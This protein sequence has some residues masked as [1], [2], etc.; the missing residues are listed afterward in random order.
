MSAPDLEVCAPWATRDLM[1]CDDAEF[2]EELIDDALDAASSILYVLSGRQFPGVCEETIRPCALRTDAPRHRRFGWGVWEWQPLWW[3][4]GCRSNDRCACGSLSQI[5]LRTPVASVD[6]VLVDG[7][8]LDPS[9]YRVD[10]WRWL[11]RVDGGAWPCCQRLEL[12]STEPDTFEVTYNWGTAPSPGGD[13]S[14]AA[15][16]CELVKAWSPETAGECRLPQRVRQLV[17]Q[18]VTIAIDNP[19]DVFNEGLTGISEVD[20]WLR[21]VNPKTDRA[22]AVICSPDVPPKRWRHV[23]T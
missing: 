10:D 16:A 18:G 8:E 17:R 11:V 1:L 5:E 20:L 19:T 13:R 6:E 2:S 23:G 21:S 14:A 3:G 12:D 15:L 9:A 4:C 7:V 22:G